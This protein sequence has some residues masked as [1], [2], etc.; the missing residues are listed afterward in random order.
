MLEAIQHLAGVMG[1]GKPAAAEPMQTTTMGSSAPVSEYVRDGMDATASKV[2]GLVIQNETDSGAQCPQD[3]ALTGLKESKLREI[4]TKL[5][6][7]GHIY[8]TIDDDHFKST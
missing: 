7:D 1:N 8:S 4:L 3:F 5:A 2:L 6:D